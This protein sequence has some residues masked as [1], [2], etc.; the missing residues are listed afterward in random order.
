M[1]DAVIRE[2]SLAGLRINVGK[3]KYMVRGD[4]AASTGDIRVG[5]SPRVTI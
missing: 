3:T 5:E 2:T 4:L 1:L